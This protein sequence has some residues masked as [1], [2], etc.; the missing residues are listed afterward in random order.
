MMAAIWSAKNYALESL[1]KNGTYTGSIFTQEEAWA[2]IAGMSAVHVLKCFLSLFLQ[3]FGQEK[4]LI[5]NGADCRKVGF[6]QALGPFKKIF[7]VIQVLV[8]EKDPVA[9]DG[10]FFTDTF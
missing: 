1:E 8:A 9:G 4:E 6:W 5:K 10:Q 2:A 7:Y 3:C